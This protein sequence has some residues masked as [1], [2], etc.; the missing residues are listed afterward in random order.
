[1]AGSCRGFQIRLRDLKITLEMVVDGFLN[2]LDHF[3][4]T[5]FWLEYQITQMPQ[6]IYSHR[7]SWLWCTYKS[8]SVGTLLEYLIITLQC[9]I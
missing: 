8:Y 9:P 6:K 1:M 4:K 2:I 7:T 3:Y 5:F